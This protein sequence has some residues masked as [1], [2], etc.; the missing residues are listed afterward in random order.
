M[1]ECRNIQKAYGGVVAV[2]NVSL[3]VE[4][5]EV[6]ALCGEN[7]AG[8]SS[9]AR[10]IAGITPPDGGEIVLAGSSEDGS[11]NDSFAVVRYNTAKVHAQSACQKRH[12]R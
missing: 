9:L 8:K 1:L 4:P 6:H 3:R 2:K 12:R 10:I 7:G 11:G 5:G